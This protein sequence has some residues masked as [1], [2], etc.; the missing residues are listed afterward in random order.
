MKSN[1]NIYESAL[2]FLSSNKVGFMVQEKSNLKLA[3]CVILQTANN[4]EAQYWSQ[5]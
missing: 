5:L 2:K 1:L 3:S 4:W